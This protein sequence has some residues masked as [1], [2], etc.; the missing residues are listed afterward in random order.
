MDQGVGGM[1]KEENGSPEPRSGS[2][3]L[4][5]EWRNLVMINYEIDPGLL[6]ADIPAGTELDFHDGRTFVSAVGFM[7]LDTRLLGL[8]IPMHRDF[9]EVNLRFYVRRKAPEG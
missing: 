4:S 7:F 3:F 2:R 1:D 9:E 5:A 6:T 8:P